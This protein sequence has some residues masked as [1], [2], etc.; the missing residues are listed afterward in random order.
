MKALLITV[1]YRTGT[2]AAGI[3][4]RMFKHM[5]LEWARKSNS[6][7]YEI[8]VPTDQDRAAEICERYRDVDGI[9]ILE[10]EAAID[11][12]VAEF[13]ERPED[14]AARYAITDPALYQASLPHV[15][16][17]QQMVRDRKAERKASTP[18]PDQ[19]ETLAALYAEGCLGI[20]RVEPR[21][22]V[23][24]AQVKARL[25]FDKQARAEAQRV[26]EREKAARK[27]KT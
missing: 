14:R 12:A 27:A 21:P 19:Q 18:E 25:D 20:A 10:D 22:P 5:P 11:A 3:S 23:T 4:E 6:I 13:I 16:L 8:R 2:R 7:G 17:I 26:R 9:V 1:N 15:A 24:A